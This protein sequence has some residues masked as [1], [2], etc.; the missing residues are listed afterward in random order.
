MEQ[1]PSNRN[2]ELDLLNE[3]LNMPSTVP[4]EPMDY[5]S[6]FEGMDQ[7]AGSNDGGLDLSAQRYLPS[8]LLDV[9][10]MM[11]RMPVP[12]GKTLIVV[13]CKVCRLKMYQIASLGYGSVCG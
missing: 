11:E 6:F 1:L 9:S 10:S 5:S 4:E 7:A 12:S 8:D 2:E 13:K 3:I